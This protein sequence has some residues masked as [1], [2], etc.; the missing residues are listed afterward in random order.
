MNRFLFNLL[1]TISRMTP[2]WAVQSRFF[3]HSKTAYAIQCWIRDRGYCHPDPEI[4]DVAARI[5]VSRED[6]T[7]Y[8]NDVLHKNFLT[9]R[10]ELR[11]M[12]ARRILKKNPK[13][14]LS[15]LAEDLGLDRSNFRRQFAEVAG[16][17]LSE[18]LAKR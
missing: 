2:S 4:D 14:N 12:E 6:L 13:M 9:W 8:C 15:R 1:R 10:K 11:I 18:W 17:S 3:S 7:A 5:G 16:E